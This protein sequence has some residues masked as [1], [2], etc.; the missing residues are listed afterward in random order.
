VA[1]TE[2]LLRVVAAARRR[3]RVQQSAA[4]AD[5]LAE[6]ARLQQ[7]FLNICRNA[8]QAT[9]ERGRI[10]IRIDLWENDRSMRIRGSEI[11]AGRFAIVSIADTGHGMGR[12]NHGPGL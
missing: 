11:R 8:V 5:V 2:H 7:V 10:E 12:S 1:E 3:T 9:N 4:D 6:A